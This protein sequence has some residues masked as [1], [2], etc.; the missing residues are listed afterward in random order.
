MFRGRQQLCVQ[1]MKPG[2]KSQYNVRDYAK[3]TRANMTKTIT[4][5]VSSNKKVKCYKHKM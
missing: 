2:Y 1:S 5:G 4:F 3:N